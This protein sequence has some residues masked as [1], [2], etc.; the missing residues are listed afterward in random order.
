MPDG[1]KIPLTNELFKSPEILFNPKIMG[2]KNYPL[3]YQLKKT[4]ENL[5]L[6]LKSFLSHHIH[7]AGGTSLIK[8]FPER[9]KKEFLK[10]FSTKQ[11][12][13]PSQE[14]NINSAWLGGSLI[15]TLSRFQSDYITKKEF[16]EN[17]SIIVQRKCFY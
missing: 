6:D 15:S 7:F 13:M 14:K 11:F 2:V 1:E 17:G 3:E 10:I 16:E 9:F 12:A 4:I 8:N 5:D